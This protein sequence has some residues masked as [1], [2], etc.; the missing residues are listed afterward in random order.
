MSNLVQFYISP[1]GSEKK[2]L[3]TAYTVKNLLAKT[4]IID[5]E[6]ESHRYPHLKKGNPVKSEPG[7]KF[8]ILLGTDHGLIQCADAKLVGLPGEPYAERTELGWAFSGHV[9]NVQIPNRKQGVIGL[10]TVLNQFV[11]SAVESS[12]IQAQ[13]YPTQHSD[14]T[15]S[16]SRKKEPELIPQT[17]LQEKVREKDLNKSYVDI[18]KQLW[19]FDHHGPEE[20]IPC[21][22][23]SFSRNQ[24]SWLTEAKRTSDKKL[25]VVNLPKKKQFQVSRPWKK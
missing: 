20:L 21:C 2:F 3:V 7:D 1:I 5:W 22:S 15:Q 18:G 23:K 14:S 4:P 6:K 13:S 11:F 9:K 8:G 19:E 17:P 10:S 25:R 24:K 12:P 16:G